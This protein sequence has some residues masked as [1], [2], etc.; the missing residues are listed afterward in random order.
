LVERLL[1]LVLADLDLGLLSAA[2]GV[3]LVDAL[4]VGLLPLWRI[5]V[6]GGW[7]EVRNA[8]AQLRRDV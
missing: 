6:G 4:L 5:R 1:A 3:V 2:A 8:D 7:I